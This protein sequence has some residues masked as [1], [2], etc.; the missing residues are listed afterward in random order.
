MF[1]LETLFAPSDE[2]FPEDLPLLDEAEPAELPEPRDAQSLPSPLELAELVRATYSD[3]ERYALVCELVRPSA[4]EQIE[5]E[6]PVGPAPVPGLPELVGPSGRRKPVRT[7]D[8]WAVVLTRYSH[9]PGPSA[10]T[11]RAV[12]TYREVGLF[13]GCTKK[14]VGDLAN[15]AAQE[16]PEA[17]GVRLLS[18][19]RSRAA[20]RKTGQTLWTLLCLDSAT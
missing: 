14:N 20:E 10:E 7:E 9:D 1:N 2:A 19:D 6:K 5:P 8:G 16:Q 4:L 13:L 15:R 12:W 18:E 3:A 11:P 17:E